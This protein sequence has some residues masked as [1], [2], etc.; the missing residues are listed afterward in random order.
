MYG[1]EEGE[2]Y[3]PW[4]WPLP[5]GSVGERRIRRK[6]GY[7]K[8]AKKLAKTRYEAGMPRKNDGAF[9]FLQTML[10]KMKP[11]GQPSQLGFIISAARDNEFRV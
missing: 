5:G 3:T 9:L 10:A 6:D 8:E 1:L 7:E 2:A 11:A 4:L